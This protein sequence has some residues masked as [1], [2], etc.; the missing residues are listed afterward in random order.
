MYILIAKCCDA[1]FDTNIYN[2]P[3]NKESCVFK[4]KCDEWIGELND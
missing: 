1:I 4:E 2:A 3:R